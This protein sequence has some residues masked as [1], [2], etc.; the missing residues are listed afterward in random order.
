MEKRENR[1][2]EENRIRLCSSVVVAEVQSLKAEF[3]VIKRSLEEEAMARKTGDALNGEVC[4]QMQAVLERSGRQQG[5]PAKF[6]EQLQIYFNKLHSEISDLRH[7]LE[8]EVRV[9]TQADENIERQMRNNPAESNL[10][11]LRVEIEQDLRKH[12][13]D[14]DNMKFTLQA[15][16]AKATRE[17]HDSRLADTSKKISSWEEVAAKERKDRQAET[18]TLHKLLGTLAEQTNLALEE[19]LDRLWKAL[20]S[21]NH[22]LIIEGVGTRQPGNVSVQTLGAVGLPAVTGSPRKIKL[23]GKA[24]P[25]ARSNTPPPVVNH[26]TVTVQ[27]SPSQSSTPVKNYSP[28]HYIS[29]REKSSPNG[30]SHQ[31]AETHHRSNASRFGYLP[32]RQMGSPM[33]CPRVRNA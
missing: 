21:H 30:V 16:V 33:P 11:A 32:E 20:R 23:N 25:R 26:N 3:E 27:V 5:T 28:V 22:D 19:E 29:P 18:R 17:S 8:A 15:E 10:R 6:E 9:R 24:P 12:V 2:L 13:V 1:R 31:H 7:G 14:I 4:L